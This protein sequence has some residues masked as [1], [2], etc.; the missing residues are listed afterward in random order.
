MAQIFSQINPFSQFVIKDI[1]EEEK[2][3]DWNLHENLFKRENHEV[4]PENLIKS[5]S[6]MYSIYRYYENPSL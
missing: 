4:N 1:C 5:S 6:Q 3:E 2:S